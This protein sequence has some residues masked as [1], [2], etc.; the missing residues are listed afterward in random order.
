MK[1]E[2]QLQNQNRALL[3]TLS[4]T[5]PGLSDDCH[6]PLLRVKELAHQLLF[7]SSVPTVTGRTLWRRHTRESTS[8]STVNSV[9]RSSSMVGEFR[10]LWPL[11]A[12]KEGCQD[13]QT[14]PPE[15]PG[16]FGTRAFLL[17]SSCAQHCPILF[18]CTPV[19]GSIAPRCKHH[20]GIQGQL[21]AMKKWEAICHHFQASP[22]SR[23]WQTHIQIPH[24]DVARDAPSRFSAHSGDSTFD[25][26]PSTAKDSRIRTCC[27]HWNRVDGHTGKCAKREARAAQGTQ[28]QNAE[29]LR[30]KP[31]M[32]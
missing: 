1:S 26:K 28:E 24:K 30:V 15:T 4:L 7:H 3:R 5:R 9:W 21:S 10:E 17:A 14:C 19:W 31:R 25:C 8:A 2:S 23:D 22:I 16:E 11:Q 12:A 27:C 18:R 29:Q 13:H 32:E 20:G 6:S